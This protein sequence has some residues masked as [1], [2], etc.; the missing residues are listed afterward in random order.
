M[1]LKNIKNNIWGIIAVIVGL[2]IAIVLGN[3]V[4]HL[5]G[6]GSPEETLVSKFGNYL[7]GA[8]TVAL[9]ITGLLKLLAPN[10]IGKDAGSMFND[11]WDKEMSGRDKVWATLITVWVLIYSLV[12][13]WK[14]S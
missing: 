2:V 4:S 5:F 8:V 10:T 12:G 1:N 14:L 6:L 13:L 9:S 11:W 3:F 7:V